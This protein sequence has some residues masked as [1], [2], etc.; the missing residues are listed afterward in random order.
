MILHNVSV[1]Q[2]KTGLH[3]VSPFTLIV[4]YKKR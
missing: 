2:I 4:V 3:N 1:S